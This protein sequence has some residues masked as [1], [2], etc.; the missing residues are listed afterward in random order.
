[1]EEKQS[2][3]DEWAELK[4]GFGI[5][6]G[7]LNLVELNRKEWRYEMALPLPPPSPVDAPILQEFLR[8]WKTLQ[9]PNLPASTNNIKGSFMRSYE[10]QYTSGEPTVA[11]EIRKSSY[12]EPRIAVPEA[13]AL[14]IKLRIR[15]FLGSVESLLYRLV[16][17][18]MSLGVRA[19]EEF[20]FRIPGPMLNNEEIPTAPAVLVY[21]LPTLQMQNLYV[22]LKV[23]KVLVGDGDIATTPYCTPVKFASKME[24]QKLVEKAVDCEVRLGRFQ[25]SLAW[26][27]MPLKKGTKQSMTLFRQRGCISEEQRISLM[28]DA[29]RGLLKEKVT[30][31]LCEF[32]VD[33][34]TAEELADAKFKSL[35]N[36]VSTPH[37]RLNILDPFSE[38]GQQSINHVYRNENIEGDTAIVCRE[39]QPF[40]TSSLIPKFGLTG[41]GPVAVS[42]VNTLYVYPL[43]LEKCLFRNIAIRIQL[44]QREIDHVSGDEVSNDA[45]LRAIYQADNQISCAAY[46]LVGYHQ[47]NPQYDDEI[48][49]CLPEC[50]T[51]NHHLLFTFY[52]V[53]CKKLQFSQSQQE[54]FGWAVIPIFGKDGTILQDGKYSVNV[55]P[56]PA[57]TKSSTTAI[58]LSS[59]YVANARD[60]ALDNNKAVFTCRCRVVS[61]IHSQDS[62]V[63]AFL[64]PFH[65]NQ[66]LNYDS[67]EEIIIRRLRDLNHSSALNARFFFFMIA[68]FVLGYL[69]YGTSIVRWSAFRTLLAIM[70][71]TSWSPRGSLKVHEMNRV[72]HDFVHVVFD[73]TSIDDPNEIHSF[74]RTSSNTERNCVYGALL[75][76]W[77]NVLTNKASVDENA[78]T[79]R[80]SLTYSNV[81]LQLVLKSMA[82]SLLDQRNSPIKGRTMLPMLLNRNDEVML[83]RL[84][85]QLVVC[86]SDTSNGLLLQKEVNRSV[87]YFCRGVFL[88]VK[89]VFPARVIDRYVKDVD[90]QG[91]ANSLRH[92]WLPFLQ[93]LVDFEF[94]PT[95]NGAEDSCA[96]KTRAWLVKAVF[97]KLLQIINTQSEQTIRV[98]SVRLLRRM[99]AAQ[100]YNPYFQSREQQETIALLYYPFFHHFAQLTTDGKVLSSSY[101]ITGHSSNG[102]NGEGKSVFTI[103]KEI[104]VCIGHLL[105]SVSTSQLSRFFLSYEGQNLTGDRQMEVGVTETLAFY[106][107]VVVKHMSKSAHQSISNE[108]VVGVHTE[109]TCDGQYLAYDEARVH[110]SLALIQRLLEI[111]LSVESSNRTNE[112]D[113]HHLLSPDLGAPDSETGLSLLENRL[114]NRHGLHRRAG[115]SGLEAIPKSNLADTMSETTQNGMDG[116]P[117]QKSLPRNWSKQYSSIQQ[118]RTGFS[119]GY[120][121]KAVSKN[122]DYE[123]DRGH[124]KQFAC[125]QQAVAETAFLVLQTA[126]DQ[127]KNVIRAIEVAY[128]PCFKTSDC[129]LMAGNA[130][131][132]AELTKQAL[133]LLGYITELFFQLLHRS[134][135]ISYLAGEVEHNRAL[136]ALYCRL[137]LPYDQCR[138]QLI[139]AIATTAKN[140]M[141][142][143][144]LLVKAPILK[145]LTAGFFPSPSKP[146]VFTMSTSSVRDMLDEMR[147]FA[148]NLRD[149]SSSL[150]SGFHLQFIELLNDLT[151]KVHAYER[152]N[153]AFQDPNGAHDVEEIEEGIDRVVRDISPHWLLEEKLIWLNALLRLHLRRGTFAE[154]VCCKLAAIECVQQSQVRSNSISSSRLH[155]WIVRELFVARSYAER[156]DWTEKELSICELLL[157]HLKQQRNFHEYREMLRCIEALIGRLAERQDP[158]GGQPNSSAFSF[159]RVRYAGGC[160]SALITRDEFI[161]KRSKFIS[162]GEFITEMKTM[163]RTKYPQ[164]ERVDVVLEPKPL[165]GS[166]SNPNVIFLRVTTVEEALANELSFPNATK[167]QLVNWRV[168]F[169]FAVPFTRGSSSAYG[170]TWEQMKRITFLLVAQEFPCHLHRQRVCLR[171][172]E[173]RSPIENSMDD[174]KKRCSLLR[175]E[176]EKECVRK[177]DLKTLTMVLKG[178]VDTHVHGGIPEV[179]ESFLASNAPQLVNA[180]GQKLGS[181]DS[182]QKRHELANLLVDFAQLCWQ[183]LLIS[184]EAFRRS[185]QPNTPHVS[186]PAALISTE[187]FQHHFDL[188]QLD[189]ANDNFLPPLSSDTE[190]PMTKVDLSLPIETDVSPRSFAKVSPL[191]TEFERSFA[192]IVDQLMT[193]IPFTYKNADKLARLQHQTIGLN[194]PTTFSTPLPVLPLPDNIR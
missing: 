94:F 67:K 32:D 36:V 41:S 127:Y 113:Y 91:D 57:T 161:Y 121:E 43:Q 157:V 53:H 4:S 132:Q 170:K 28:S 112:Q 63:A 85:N 40:C 71:K 8:P 118:R 72:L 140:F 105:Y 59:G 24:Q 3:I 42:Y 5:P 101:P 128:K 160:V 12:L 92:I 162:L 77:L 51:A 159:Y 49:I 60:V 19:T 15:F 17:Y 29:I 145:V 87:A 22:L 185:S 9:L 135:S 74:S 86:A 167:S 175:A 134:S 64:S 13:Q 65:G 152:W 61:S 181:H 146:L 180:E 176:I 171:Y 69:R 33:T 56:A 138:T 139:L 81:L 155:E 25:Q 97:E 126:V 188:D 100:A 131:S 7:T 182:L 168:A 149:S 62:A 109:N 178:S 2:P 141:T 177:T 122:I 142:G 166:E 54:L 123:Q 194:V 58:L 189:T 137:P 158:G 114:V 37:P 191:Q 83:E 163:L 165:A 119:T 44:L 11:S 78:E 147:A 192:S 66:K 75:E 82:M 108:N 179:L 18:D 70:E 148:T 89:N 1:M 30:P 115:G 99:F 102:L 88:V 34:I 48:K 16:V 98:D 47:K 79:R 124:R 153:N 26:G 144:F 80:I 68:K 90:V 104:M 27:T 150:P 96:L 116:S 172:E 73:E 31:A 95:V 186:A 136:L 50:L 125:L 190:L 143:S 111:F 183:C 45:F 20:C 133:V 169:K 164:C 10:P 21:V 184:R 156:A 76:T 151:T 6:P 93:I 193:Q 117:T 174:I 55:N 23:S 154:A 106:R 107:R 84:L 120:E 39:I 130:A 187:L 129:S 35:G 103:Q 52:H 14:L 173:L 46:A 110:A 38:A